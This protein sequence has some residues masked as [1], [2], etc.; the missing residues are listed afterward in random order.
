MKNK[1]GILYMPTRKRSSSKK[2]ITITEL[3]LL[4]KF[5]YNTHI[6]KEDRHHALDKAVNEYGEL[7]V[8]HRVNAI[9]T[10]NKSHLT[11]WR[12]LDNDVKYLQKKYFP[13]R[14]GSKKSSARPYTKKEISARKSK[15]RK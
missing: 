3:G 10:F 7:K 11:T 8:L 4:R 1:S 15:T 13:K 2:I 6:S 12:K 9:R 5:G 14:K